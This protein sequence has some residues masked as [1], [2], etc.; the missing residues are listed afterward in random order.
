M[1]DRYY[2]TTILCSKKY[3]TIVSAIVHGRFDSP[4]CITIIES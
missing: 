3:Q 2:S 1:L 4:A